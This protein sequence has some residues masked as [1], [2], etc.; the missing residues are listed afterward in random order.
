MVDVNFALEA[1][2]L[3]CTVALFREWEQ[4]NTTLLLRWIRADVL[5]SYHQQWILLVRGLSAGGKVR[6]L[7]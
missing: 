6:T 4:S 1:G 3:R 5:V 2:P 7:G